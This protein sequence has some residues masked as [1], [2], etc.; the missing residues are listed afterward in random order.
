MNIKSRS[1][2][3][4]PY[5]ISFNPSHSYPFTSQDPL[6]PL[7]FP[8]SLNLLFSHLTSFFPLNLQPPPFSL[9]PLRSKI[10]VSKVLYASC[11]LSLPFNPCP[12]SPLTYYL[13][14]IPPHFPSPIIKTGI[15]ALATCA[16]VCEILNRKC[17]IVS[18]CIR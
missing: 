13:T 5:A 10:P 17:S 2:G 9:N 11:I 3:L 6:N 18:Q 15:I 16:K 1:T 12:L 7:P 4:V 14:L 8:F